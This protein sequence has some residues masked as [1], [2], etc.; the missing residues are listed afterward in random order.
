MI[1]ECTHG[2]LFFAITQLPRV[3]LIKLQQDNPSFVFFVVRVLLL[4]SFV[5]LSLGP[6]GT[7]IPLHQRQIKLMAE[8]ST[9][10]FGSCS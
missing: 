1:N 9:C 8:S 3:I 7:K 2:K 4:R 5:L 10:A 6:V